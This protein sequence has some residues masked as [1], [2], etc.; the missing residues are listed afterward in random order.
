MRAPFYIKKLTDSLDQWIEAG[1]VPEASRSK[2]IEHAKAQKSGTNLVGVLAIL[3]A[4]LLGFAAISFVASNWANMGKMMR[5]VVMLSAL[6]AAFG[7]AAIAAWRNVMVY[8]HA[9]GLLGAALFGA[10]IMLIAQTFNIQ[11]YYPGGVLIWFFGALSA[12]IILRSNPILIFSAL[13]AGLW[14]MMA[15]EGDVPDTTQYW[16]F[17][18][19]A[20]GVGF[21]A[22]RFK[23][24][25]TINILAISILLFVPAYLVAEFDYRPFTD[26]L[27]L[28]L[29]G[30]VFITVALLTAS[31]KRFIFGSGAIIG[32]MAI[33]ALLVGFLVQLV[34]ADGNLDNQRI[35]DQWHLHT[36]V[37]LVLI[38]GLLLWLTLKKQMKPVLAI[39]ILFG[40]ALMAYAPLVQAPT[41]NLPIQMLYGA[42]FFGICVALLISGMTTHK[43]SLTWIGGVGFGAQ[44]LYVYFETFKDLLNTS[45]FFLVG[46]LLLLGISLLALRLNK[47]I[48]Q[49]AKS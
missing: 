40:T 33:S 26:G 29:S 43:N 14:M 36:V 37:L 31:L 18:L 25:A 16:L 27:L 2:I 20:I 32:W 7:I 45:L 17:P 3:G 19:F 1:W 49:E 39:G 15:F 9:F 47:Q 13:L 34:L 6:W 5:M 48:K 30:A 46:G 28:P 11:A 8:A 42:A 38:A 44:A 41:W 12:A 35:S 4:V 10:A 22:S 21:T 24:I 23:S